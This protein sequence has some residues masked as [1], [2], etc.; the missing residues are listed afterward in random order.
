MREGLSGST[1]ARIKIGIEDRKALVGLRVEGLSC[2]AISLL[3][4]A[5]VGWVKSGL[6]GSV[7]VIVVIPGLA[8]RG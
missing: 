6:T 2:G 7:I 1:G 4:T 5:H 8:V 3:Q